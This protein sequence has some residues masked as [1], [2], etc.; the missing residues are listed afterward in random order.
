MPNRRYTR[1]K[2]NRNTQ[3]EYFRPFGRD[4]VCVSRFFTSKAKYLTAKVLAKIYPTKHLNFVILTINH[5][6][7]MKIFANFLD[8]TTF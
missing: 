7:N 3:Y 8:F 6:S 2:K 4:P 1:R 5:D